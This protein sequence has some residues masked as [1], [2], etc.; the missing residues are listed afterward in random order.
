MMRVGI[1]YWIFLSLSWCIASAQGTF[2]NSPDYAEETSSPHRKVYQIEKI[3]INTNLPVK[4]QLHNYNDVPVKGAHL[5]MDGVFV[6]GSSADDIYL[7]HTFTGD[8]TILTSKFTRGTFDINCKHDVLQIPNFFSTLLE[9]E[10]GIYRVMVDLEGM[11]KKNMKI[12]FELVEIFPSSFQT[13]W[14]EICNLENSLVGVRRYKRVNNYDIV[15]SEPVGRPPFAFISSVESDNYNWLKSIRFVREK[16]GRKIAISFKDRNIDLIKSKFDEIQQTICSKYLASANPDKIFTYDENGI[17]L[18]A[19]EKEL[20]GILLYLKDFLL[21]PDVWQV[22]RTVPDLMPLGYDPYLHAH[23]L[24]QEKLQ[25]RQFVNE[26]H[27]EVWPTLTALPHP[28][29]SSLTVALIAN[30]ILKL[31]LW[32]Y[33]LALHLFDYIEK[34]YSEY[35]QRAYVHLEE[36]KYQYA[37]SILAWDYEGYRE[38]SEKSQEVSIIKNEE[39]FEMSKYALLFSELIPLTQSSNC[40]LASRAYGKLVSFF[41]GYYFQER[42]ED[43]K[44]YRRRDI[45]WDARLGPLPDE[46][47]EVFIIR[48]AKIKHVIAKNSV[49]KSYVSL[50]ACLKFLGEENLL[51]K[52][53]TEEKA[54]QFFGFDILNW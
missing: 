29:S 6:V 16:N 51:V 18:V 26:F 32:E 17:Y 9:Q 52:S 1:F 39:Q 49:N 37:E 33:S 28:E 21:P 41:K 8:P 36:L 43:T 5:S 24:I 46:S 38:K 2:L 48:A 14:D 54:S 12:R 7:P 11:T 3:T 34:P 31:S 23:D 20:L 42:E 27:N 44:L 45:G 10:P 15:V 22:L 47:I 35:T 53:A 19:D 50:T 4:C 13:E 25:A 30:L 40:A